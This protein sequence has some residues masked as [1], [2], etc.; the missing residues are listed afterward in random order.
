MQDFIKISMDYIQQNL[1][2]DI[3][4]EEL[5]ANVKYSAG[6]FCRIFAQATNLTVSHYI[7][8]SRIDQAL[9]EISSGRK[10]VDAAFEYGFQTYSGFYKAFV[11][12][13]GC[14]P[15]QYLN[16]HKREEKNSM[17]QKYD[18]RK[19]LEN[20]DLPQ[21]IEVTDASARN[22][23][24]GETEWKI[25]KIGSDSYLKTNE[26]SIMIKNIRIAKAL[27]KEGLKSE[28]LPIPTKTGR[29]YPDGEPIFLL[30][31]RVGEP[32]N[33]RPLSDAELAAV[34]NN[35]KREKY[36]YQLGKAIAKVHRALKTIQDDVK[37]YEAN[38]YL[39]G[40][41]SIPQVKELLS[42]YKIS[43]QESFFEEYTHTFGKLYEYL[44]KQLIH[45]NPTAETVLYEKGEVT[46]IK[47]Y[48]VYNISHVRLFDLTW[49]A[50]EII[51]HEIDTYLKRLQKILSGYNSLCPLTREEKQAVYFVLCANAMNCAAYCGDAL[52]VTKRNLNAL[53]FLAENKEKFDHLIASGDPS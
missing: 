17:E 37:P 5:A 29:E 10:A 47:G 3:T 14:S 46:G 32:L 26:R 23:K 16:L 11:K 21:N 53:A 38:L 34:K 12:L 4:V 42:R 40:L 1:K 7:L 30:T 41:H 44:P 35:E 2:T 27:K 6:H 13:Y 24:T 8:K 25:W 28:F 49:S 51:P 50:G 45:G 20:W 22:W 33:D 15:K 48:E 18:I 36:A 9:I 52:D 31:K 43:I 19:I 39:Q